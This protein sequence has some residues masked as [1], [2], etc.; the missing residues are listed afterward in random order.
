MTPS[1]VFRKSEAAYEI[2]KIASV[3]IA[4]GILLSI[5]LSIFN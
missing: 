1:K 4:F 3:V 5:T 2:V